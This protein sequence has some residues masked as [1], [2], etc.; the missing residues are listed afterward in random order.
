MERELK[1][2]SKHDVYELVAAPQGRKIIFLIVWYFQDQGIPD[3]LI[4]NEG[5][6]RCLFDFR[7]A[8]VP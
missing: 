5:P 8:G 1:S 3:D 6:G 4:R 2:M 7:N